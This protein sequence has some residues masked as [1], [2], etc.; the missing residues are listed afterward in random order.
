MAT[1]IVH[2]EKGIIQDKEALTLLICNAW[3]SSIRAAI[4]TL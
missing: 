4:A 2:A 3:F 1:Y